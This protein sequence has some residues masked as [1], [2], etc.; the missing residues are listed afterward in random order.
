MFGAGGGFYNSGELGNG[1]LTGNSNVAIKI[2][3]RADS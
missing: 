1:S 3:N 2:L